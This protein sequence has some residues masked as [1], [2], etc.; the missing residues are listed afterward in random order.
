MTLNMRSKCRKVAP[1]GRVWAKHSKE[2]EQKVQIPIGIPN[3]VFFQGVNLRDWWS[4]ANKGAVGMV[5][6]NREC[7]T[8]CYSCLDV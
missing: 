3:S 5:A 6:D 2:R 8:C 4:T 7:W 1:M